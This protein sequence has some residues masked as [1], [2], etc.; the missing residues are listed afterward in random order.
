MNR[1]LFELFF[2]IFI[3]QGKLCDG[4]LDCLDYSD[5]LNCDYCRL[6][7]STTA[8]DENT[9]DNIFIC[10]NAKSCIRKDQGKF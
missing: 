10:P 3:K 1:T 7:N 8:N 2:F 4:I 9:V 6:I 5:E